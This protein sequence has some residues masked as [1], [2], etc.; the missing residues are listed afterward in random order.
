[1]KRFFLLS[2]LVVISLLIFASFYFRDINAQETAS[3]EDIKIMEKL[4]KIIENQNKIFLKLE[5]LQ[6]EVKARCS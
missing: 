5:G 4:D 6:Q 1:M 2:A 3:L